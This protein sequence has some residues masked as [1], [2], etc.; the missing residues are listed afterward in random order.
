M[1]RAASQAQATEKR[2]WLAI[3]PSRDP[4]AARS[5]GPGVAHWSPRQV[6]RFVIFVIFVAFMIFVAFV[7][8]TGSLSYGANC[9]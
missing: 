6:R 3:G 9:K 7:V 2:A 5:G 8:S 4:S 1:N